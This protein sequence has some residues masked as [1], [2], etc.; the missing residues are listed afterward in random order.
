MEKPDASSELPQTNQWATEFAET[1]DL[2]GAKGQ[3]RTAGPVCVTP[4]QLLLST[5]HAYWQ[6]PFFEGHPIAQ[7]FRFC[8]KRCQV[9]PGTK[10]GL[11][12]AKLPDMI[13]DHLSTPGDHDSSGLYPHLNHFTGMLSV[14]T[15]MATLHQDCIH[16]IDCESPS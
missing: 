9:M 16:F 12:M 13:R 15:K 4:A 7:G 3:N 5:M 1:H 14:Y 11:A 10:N 6:I 8:L 2:T